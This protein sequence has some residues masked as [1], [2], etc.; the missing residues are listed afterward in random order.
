MEMGFSLGAYYRMI[1]LGMESI[2]Q[3]AIIRHYTYRDAA[4]HSF[5]VL[6][7][8]QMNA[9]T[10]GNKFYKLYFN[11]QK[12]QQQGYP[13]ILTFGGAYSN[14]IEATAKAAQAF[15]LQS[16]G[17]IRG[18][19]VDPLNPTLSD[20]EKAGMQLHFISRSEYRHKTSSDFIEKLKAQFG[21]FYLIPE[22]GS[23]DLAVKGVA[24]MPIPEG[25]DEVWCAVGTGGTLTGLV[26]HPNLQETKVVGVSALKGIDHWQE[27]SRQFPAVKSHQVPLVYE[28]TVFGGYAKHKP[29]LLDFIRSFWQQTGLKL[30]PIYTGKLFYRF[31]QEGNPKAKTLLIHSGG[32]QGIRGFEERFSISLFDQA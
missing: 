10:H 14:H 11:L 24:R 7:L 9:P 26:L 28:E 8:E 3:A 13:K 15:G 19:R 29:A 4:V 23:N 32:L 17:I 2:G 18:E 31:I 30:D 5:D 22:G 20:A 21:D 1:N 16:I 25:Y 12:A 27:I 6:H